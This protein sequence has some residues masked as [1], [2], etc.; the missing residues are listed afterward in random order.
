MP[1]G[2]GRPGRALPRMPPVPPLPLA[3]P[4]P[5]LPTG[6]V[7]PSPTGRPLPAC[8]PLPAMNPLPSPTGRFGVA[9][10]P[11]LPA[12]DTLAPSPTG[13]ARPSVTVVWPPAALPALPITP[14]GDAVSA[15]LWQANGTPSAASKHSVTQPRRASIWRRACIKTPQR[16]AFRIHYAY[17]MQRVKR[18]RVSLGCR[19][20]AAT[21]GRDATVS[22]RAARSRTRRA[23]RDRTWRRS[24]HR[25]T[26]SARRAT[27]SLRPA[28]SA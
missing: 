9:R 20:D 23:D 28:P 11:P 25:P 18:W 6:I 22:R 17:V 7:A 13:N 14:C 16:N 8:P 2:R 5:P 3:P 27:G 21:A 10:C 12:I 26:R 19:P 15:P 4:F 1:P 24:G